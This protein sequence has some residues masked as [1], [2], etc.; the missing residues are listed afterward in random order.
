MARLFTTKHIPWYAVIAL[1]GI[2]GIAS[3]RKWRQC[4]R[5]DF[6]ATNDEGA[7]EGGRVPI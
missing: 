5:A 7:P 6:A 4:L 1:C 2:A 3:Y